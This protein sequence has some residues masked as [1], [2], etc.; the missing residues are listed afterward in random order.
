M[1]RDSSAIS[2]LKELPADWQLRLAEHIPHLCPAKDSGCSIAGANGTVAT[3][4]RSGRRGS[5]EY[6]SRLTRADF[7]A[8]VAVPAHGRDLPG[9]T[10]HQL[11]SAD[12]RSAA[13]ENRGRPLFGSRWTTR[14][15]ASGCLAFSRPMDRSRAGFAVVSAS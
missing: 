7:L 3:L 10:R 9:L 4:E 6:D 1:F 14:P 11:R 15:D 13:D 12:R 8:Y 2:A 5:E